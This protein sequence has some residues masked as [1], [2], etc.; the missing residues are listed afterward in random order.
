MSFIGTW[1]ASVSVQV[2]GGSDSSTDLL[3]ITSEPT[4]GAQLQ[5]LRQDVLNFSTPNGPCGAVISSAYSLTVKNAS[6]A[7]FTCSTSDAG[8]SVT[9]AT[10]GITCGAPGSL[11][12]LTFTLQGGT[13]NG[14]GFPK[15]ESFIRSDALRSVEPDRKSTFHTWR[16]TI[17]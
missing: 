2:E 13:L 14:T 17:T 6:E 9:G 4:A 7:S 12:D 1:R 3:Q 8:C 16:R 11:P 10:C 5:L 15:A